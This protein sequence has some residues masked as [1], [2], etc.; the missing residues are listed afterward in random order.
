MQVHDVILL[1]KFLGKLEQQSHLEW[2]FLAALFSFSL[3]LLILTESIQAAC[4]VNEYT[5]IGLTSLNHLIIDVHCFPIIMLSEF[6]CERT[7]L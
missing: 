4:F 3:C 7:Y 6:E 1:S 5:L 2:S